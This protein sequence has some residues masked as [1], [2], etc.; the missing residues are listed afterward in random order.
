MPLTI[1]FLA[2]TVLLVGFAIVFTS[3]LPASAVVAVSGVSLT[4]AKTSVKSIHLPPLPE[5]RW[6]YVAACADADSGKRWGLG[7]HRVPGWWMAGLQ[8]ESKEALHESLETELGRRRH[9]SH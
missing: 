9:G 8:C 6:R 4:F 2:V 5:S 1:P 7:A 3:T